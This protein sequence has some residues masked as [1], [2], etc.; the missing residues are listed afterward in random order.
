MPSRAATV[1]AI[2]MAGA[3]P[4]LVWGGISVIGL[5]WALLI[6]SLARRLIWLRAHKDELQG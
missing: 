4:W 3:E 1:A 6:I 2:R 5:G